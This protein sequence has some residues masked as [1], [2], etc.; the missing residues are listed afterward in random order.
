MIRYLHIKNLA[1]VETAEIAFEKGLNVLTGETGAGKTIV[2]TALGLI[3]GSRAQ[4]SL[5][6]TG[7][8]KASV[9]ASFELAEDSPT[10]KLLEEMGIESEPSDLLT[11]RRELTSEG[12]S[13][14]QINCQTVP[15][16]LLQKVGS[17]LCDLIDQ[18]SHQELKQTESQRDLLD[19]YAGIEPQ[20]KL[21]GSL[22]EK[23]KEVKTELE[24]L[25][26][27]SQKRDQESE[28]LT[29]QL[30]EL[31]EVRLHE[32]ESCFAEYQLLSKR[33]ELLE[34]L[35]S[36]NATLADSPQAILTQLARL[37]GPLESAAKIDPSLEKATA[38][39]QEAFIPLREVSELL[40]SS[41]DQEEA[42]P[43][44]LAHLE[45]RLSKMHLLKRKIGKNTKEEI[46]SYEEGL[47]TK[48][49]TL[50]S[51]GEKVKAQEVELARL[52]KETDNLARELTAARQKAAAGWKQ[53]LT[54]CLQSFNMPSAELQLKIEKQ[55]RCAH[56]DDLFLFSMRANRGESLLPIQACASG[57]ELSRLLLSIKTT[58]AEKNRTPILVF[59]EIDANVG[60][61]TATL[62]GAQLK[63][64]ASVRQ[65]IC[66]THFPQVARFADRHLQLKKSEESGRTTTTVTAL[67]KREKEKELLRMLGGAGIL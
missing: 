63:K 67:D 12:K 28:F 59:D 29:Y 27:L 51:L 58:L 46:E 47:K 66:V 43:K 38:L 35:H 2:L 11:I 21:F 39:F 41:L 6:R 22:W 50:A 52:Q 44:R 4:S 40:T 64:L 56:G 20:V 33:A 31:Q 45:E 15:L 57:G 17:T 61:E 1:L 53:E 5:L 54:A 16:P 13:R 34:R 37:K 48:L 25:L 26:A 55:P 42:D 30:E 7:A 62:I 14:A 65:L 18:S 49:E 3:L 8:D 23:E 32:E 36:I 60:G 19:L 24:T 9:E 10:W